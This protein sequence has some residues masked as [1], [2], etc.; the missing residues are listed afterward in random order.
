M[1]DGPAGPTFIPLSVPLI[2]GNEWRYVK[3]CLD[4]G[5]VSS[6]G[7][8][9]TRFENE[10]AAFVGAPHAIACVN[11]TAA[12]QVALRLT[13]VEA[14]EEVIVPTVTFI[15]T[16][17]AVRYVGAAPVFMDCDRYYNLDVE[18][19]L[20]FLDNCVAFRDGHAWNRKTKRRIAAVMA[21][22]VFGNAADLA[23]LLA[24]CRKLNIPLVED[25]AESLGTYYTAG[26]LKGKHTG[27]VGDIGCFSFNGNKIV[28]CGGG[29][30]IVTADP[31]LADR[32]RYLTTQAKDDSVYFV[33]HEVGYNYRL[34]NLQAAVGVAQLEQ[35]RNFIA[36]KKRN[37]LLYQAGIASAPGLCLGDPPPYA[38]CNMWLYCLQIR[39]DLYGADRNAV[40]AH[41]ADR[42]VQSRPMW[43]LNHLQR[44]YE[45][46]ETYRI[47]RA[48]ALYDCTLNL[49]SSSNLSEADIERIV[50]YLT[51]SIPRASRKPRV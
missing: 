17:N 26:P 5:W 42:G 16:V 37:F 45:A 31:A 14:G 47:E 23:P 22:H 13:G 43:Y 6:V 28:T 34:T 9:V 7:S 38:D 44:P 46:C 39:K 35:I 4:S 48:R 15:A 29:G 24:A 41:L 32:A 27:A 1:R 12:L 40:M 20:D 33:H 2:Q 18:K 19:T 30:M 51:K 36:S 11:G 10:L 8:Y 49:P 25:A 50:G 21:V 3:E